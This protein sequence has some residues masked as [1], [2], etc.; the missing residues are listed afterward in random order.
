MVTTLP[1]QNRSRDEESRPRRAED[2]AVGSTPSSRSP[3]G[4]QLRRRQRAEN[5]P[6]ALRVLPRRYRTHLEAV[7]GVARVVDDLG[8]EAAGDR[9]AGLLA[10]RADLARVWS[11]GDPADPVLR[12]L[13]PTVRACGL[14]EEPFDRLVRANLADQQVTAYPRWSD[15]LAYCALSADPVG[16]IVL[17]VFGVRSGEA[18]RLSDRVCTALQVIEHCQDVAEDRRAGRVYLP[19]E[20]LAAHGVDPADLDGA[21]TPPAVRRLVAFEAARAADL[22]A[23]GAPLLGLLRGWARLAV[24]GYVAGGLAALDALRRA[25]WAVLEGTPRA[26]RRDVL[27]HLVRLAATRRGSAP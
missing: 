19:A 12:R 6:V 24:A 1:S 3:V 14:A 11:G 26:R 13:V 10:F 23:A 5:F 20:D 7:Y 17:A 4:A 16:R 25:D 8:D 2:G 22:L 15:L 27:R 18:E 21:A 9:T